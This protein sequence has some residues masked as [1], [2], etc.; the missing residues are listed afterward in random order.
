[1][2]DQ[3]RMQFKDIG[4]KPFLF[5]VVFGVDS[6]SL[7]V[8]KE[9][10]HV[11]E[12]PEGLQVCSISREDNAEYIDGFFSDPLGSILKEEN[13]DLFDKCRSC[14]DCVIINGDIVNDSNFNYM[15]NVI[16]MIQA[17][18]EKGAAGILDM[19]TFSLISPSGWTEQFFEKDINAQNHVK[20]L[21]SEEADGYWLHTR[22]M[23][24]F[25]RPDYSIQGVDESDFDEYS[26]VL[27]QM[28]FYGGE[29]VFFNGEFRLHTQI[30]NSYKVTSEFVEDFENDDFNNAYCNVTIEPEE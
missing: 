18:V 30:G 17:L 5:F 11:D 3:A 13:P 1:M 26:S 20:I 12:I 24:E 16:G 8:S 6:D 10:H 27:N 4:Y 21:F 23:I 28:I 9:K 22:G 29:G 14:N 15:R 25:G 19:L 2:E 7:E